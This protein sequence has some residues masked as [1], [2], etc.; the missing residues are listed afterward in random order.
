[1]NTELKKLYED[2]AFG[3]SSKPKFYKKAKEL[4]P[5]LTLKQ[6]DE[7]LKSQAVSQIVKPVNKKDRVYNT[8]VSL[9][10]RNNCQIDIVVK[11]TICMQYM[12]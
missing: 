2:P 4:I 7:F 5:N 6:V 11:Y 8:I 1:M 10:V 9:G 12:L 3:L